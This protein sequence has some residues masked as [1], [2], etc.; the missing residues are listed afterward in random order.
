MCAYVLRE[1]NNSS[2]ESLLFKEG[3][4]KPE[5]EGSLRSC[6]RLGGGRFYSLWSE[7][8]VLTSEIR[9][10]AECG[11]KS[12]GRRKNEQ[13]NVGAFICSVN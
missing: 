7:G 8:E 10:Q 11:C 13:S 2:V 3:V 12:D 1:G 4:S 6:R 5:G 9:R